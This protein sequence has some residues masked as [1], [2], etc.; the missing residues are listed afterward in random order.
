MFN[1]I[2]DVL[3]KL[4][5]VSLKVGAHWSYVLSKVSFVTVGFYVSMFL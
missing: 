2:M 4:N 3:N 1:A 5:I